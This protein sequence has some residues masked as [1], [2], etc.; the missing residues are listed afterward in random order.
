MI[1]AAG[2]GLIA[3]V[4]MTKGSE[5]VPMLIPCE[6]QAAGAVRELPAEEEVSLIRTSPR[7]VRP[8]F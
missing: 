7:K 6:A 3:S 2:G 1:A 5:E 4:T 8:S